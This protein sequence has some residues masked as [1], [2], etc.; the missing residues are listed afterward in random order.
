VLCQDILRLGLF[1]ADITVPLEVPGEVDGLH[2][3]LDVHL[4]V[5]GEV[6]GLHVVLDVHLPLVLK[7]TTAASVAPV[8]LRDEEHQVVIRPNQGRVKV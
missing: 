5:P 8:C 6:D 1:T 7:G 2:V 4:E 3:V